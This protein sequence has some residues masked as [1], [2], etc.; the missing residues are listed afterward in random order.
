MPREILPPHNRKADIGPPLPSAVA[1]RCH[2]GKL[3]LLK[4]DALYAHDDGNK[5]DQK[6]E[7]G[8]YRD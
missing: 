5:R 2:A 1:G 8:K 7:T 4:P 3:P 6:A